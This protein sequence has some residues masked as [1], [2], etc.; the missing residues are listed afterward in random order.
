[1]GSRADRSEEVPPVSRRNWVKEFRAATATFD[2]PL[3]NELAHSYA[4]HL[5]AV[6]ALPGSVGRVLQELRQ[7]LRYTE[8]ELVADAALAHGPGLPV[9]RR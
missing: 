7:A 1:M 6:P 8:L 3:V 2:W 5:Y 4:A 9:V